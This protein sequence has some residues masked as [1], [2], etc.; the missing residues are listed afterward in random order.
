MSYFFFYNNQQ[1]SIRQVATW[2]TSIILIFLVAALMYL[3]SDAVTI[4]L[5]L[6]S[7]KERPLAT[8]VKRQ[9]TVYSPNQSHSNNSTKSMKTT[10]S[11]SRASLIKKYFPL[12]S[13]WTYK[14]KSLLFLQ[15]IRS[16]VLSPNIKLNVVIDIKKRR[17]RAYVI[18]IDIERRLRSLAI[19]FFH[20]GKKLRVNRQ[21]WKNKMAGVTPY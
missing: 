3:T 8:L 11:V 2:V 4:E 15:I 7:P 18:S 16:P 20:H 21:W 19:L 12:V 1:F 9:Y 10:Q 17:S 6:P 13:P 14:L 5:R